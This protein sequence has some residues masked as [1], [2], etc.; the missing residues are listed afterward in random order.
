MPVQQLNNLDECIF[1][2]ECEIFTNKNMNDWL[3]FFNFFVEAHGV[4]YHSATRVNRTKETGLDKTNGADK[5][6]KGSK[7]A[8]HYTA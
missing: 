2:N 6:K 8:I 1:P 4:E 7:M 3:Y 5:W